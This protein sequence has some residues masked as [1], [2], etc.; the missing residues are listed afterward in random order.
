[1]LKQWE[2][3]QLDTMRSRRIQRAMEEAMVEDFGES[4][5]H[6]QSAIDR[7]VKRQE[8]EETKER[9]C[10]K[11]KRGLL[12]PWQSENLRMMGSQGPK[13]ITFMV[14]KGG[15]T[16]KTFLGNYLVA[17]GEALYFSGTSPVSLIGGM[18]RGTLFFITA[19]RQGTS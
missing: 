13:C 5:I 10:E 4:W 18:V 8:A 6:I 11:G 2:K 17:T 3:G 16:G 7:S 15:N 9:L 12:Q 19:E 1:M 14:D